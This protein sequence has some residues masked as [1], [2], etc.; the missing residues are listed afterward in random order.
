MEYLPAQFPSIGITAG[1]SLLFLHETKTIV[2]K[3][4]A[5]KNCFKYMTKKLKI[6]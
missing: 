3:I 1:A 5:R 2:D 4:A 6:Y